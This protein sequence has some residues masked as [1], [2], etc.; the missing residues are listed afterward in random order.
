MGEEG[1]VLQ[2]LQPLP[3]FAGNRPVLGS[4]V[5]AGKAA[6][7]GIREGREAVT[8]DRAR[9]LPHVILG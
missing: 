5:V 7:M 1:F 8:T 3:D 4:W 9:F 6:G 2:A